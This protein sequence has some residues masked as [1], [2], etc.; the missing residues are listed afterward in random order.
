MT[1][2]I[3][4]IYQLCQ[5]EIFKDST[6]TES[7]LKSWLANGDYLLETPLVSPSGDKKANEFMLQVNQWNSLFSALANDCNRFSQ[8]AIE[9][10]W[11]IRKDEKLP[12][13]A[14]WAAYAAHAILRLFGR[15][16]TQLERLHVNKVH[17]IAVATSMDNGV[18]SIEQ[19]FYLSA[20]DRANSCVEYKKLKDSHADTWSSFHRLLIWLSD[21]IQGKTKGIGEDKLDAMRLVSKTKSAITRSGATGGNWLSQVRNKIHYQHSHGVWFPYKAAIHDQNSI[22]RNTQWLNAPPFFNLDSANNDDI[23]LLHNVSNS[24]LS[25]MFHL[26]KYGF[27]RTGEKSITLRNG[28]FRLINQIQAE[29]K[30]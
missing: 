23:F 19:G 18:T 28:T 12:K 30:R 27:E 4:I 15:G 10:M 20:I 8:A 1:P 5:E 6:Q 9:S 26:M 14:G 24:I 13:S 11:L 22:M 21:N 29:Q 25:M 17:D 7:D 2:E 16:C 3:E